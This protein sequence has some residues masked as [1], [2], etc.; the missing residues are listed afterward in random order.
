MIFFGTIGE[1]AYGLDIQ[2]YE[3]STIHCVLSYDSGIMFI[4]KLSSFR[5]AYLSI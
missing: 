5:D 4:L 1:I 2:W 3:G